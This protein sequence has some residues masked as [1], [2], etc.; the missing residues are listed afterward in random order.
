M[1]TVVRESASAYLLCLL[2]VLSGCDRSSV[3]HVVVPVGYRG[4]F[5]IGKSPG[6]TPPPYRS[7]GT[8]VIKIPESGVLMIPDTKILTSIQ[9]LTA[10]FSS[11]EKLASPV[12]P[13][14]VGS[15]SDLVLRIVTADSAGWFYFAV[16][17]E[18]GIAKRYKSGDFRLGGVI[19][20]TP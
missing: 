19:V 17:T 3:I 16:D 12:L 7:D 8:V 6:S 11:G 5:K 15:G 1:Y 2:V 13:P 9:G 14:S 20:S 10:E 4:V 18:D